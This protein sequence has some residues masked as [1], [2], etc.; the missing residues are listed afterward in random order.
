MK[1]NQIR[2]KESTK[3][4]R[5][6]TSRENFKENAVLT[7]KFLMELINK[8][9]DEDRT[10]VQNELLKKAKVEAETCGAKTQ[11]EQ[12]YFILLRDTIEANVPLPS[13]GITD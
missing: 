3:W 4:N 6:R 9:N 11:A 8:I 2:K 12:D 10:I 7:C 1:I 13:E 5:N